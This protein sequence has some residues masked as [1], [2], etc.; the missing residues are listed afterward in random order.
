MPDRGELGSE[1]VLKLSLS[2]GKDCRG[3]NEEEVAGALAGGP[4][5][6][7]VRSLAGGGRMISSAWAFRSC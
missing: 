3:A 7:A 6:A 2:V 5:M 4:D 1:S